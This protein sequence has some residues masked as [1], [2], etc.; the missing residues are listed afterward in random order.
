[1]LLLNQSGAFL[2]GNSFE[3]QGNMR[4]PGVFALHWYLGTVTLE[5][6]KPPENLG[7][8]G[9]TPGDLLSPCN[10]VAVG[11]SCRLSQ[12]LE[13]ST[14]TVSREPALLELQTDHRQEWW[15][16]F[17]LIQKHPAPRTVLHLF[18]QV[19]T[20]TGYPGSQQPYWISG[21]F[22]V[23]NKMQLLWGVSAFPSREHSSGVFGLQSLSDFQPA[24]DT[25]LNKFPLSALGSGTGTDGVAGREFALFV[26]PRLLLGQRLEELSPNSPYLMWVFI[27]QWERPLR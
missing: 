5:G 9:K 10:W 8:H 7:G 20:T 15:F 21:G 14:G 23:R 27:Q 13:R 6:P 11:E 2:Q 1:M 3:R 26:S 25:G 19:S 17:Y 24:K 18:L 22:A 12:F 4:L 16:F